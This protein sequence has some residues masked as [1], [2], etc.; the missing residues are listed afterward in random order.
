MKSRKKPAAALNAGILPDG[1]YSLPEQHA[2]G[3]GPDVLSLQ[4]SPEDDD[5]GSSRTRPTGGG[6]GL[7]VAPQGLDVTAETD[8]EFYRRKATP[9]SFAT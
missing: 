6:A 1:Y 7:L 4:G 5:N 9:W 8:M 2:A 3:F